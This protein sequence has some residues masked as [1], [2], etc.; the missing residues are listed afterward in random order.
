MPMGE[1][2]FRGLNSASEKSR[3]GGSGHADQRRRM[4]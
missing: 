4:L 2:P 3:S 1:G